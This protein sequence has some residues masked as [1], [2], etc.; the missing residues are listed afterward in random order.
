MQAF[1]RTVLALPKAD[2]SAVLRTL[3]GARS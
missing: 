3:I 2:A 1:Y